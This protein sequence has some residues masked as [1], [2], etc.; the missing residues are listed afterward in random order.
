MLVIK[1]VSNNQKSTD[2]KAKISVYFPKSSFASVEVTAI[3][4]LVCIFLEHLYKL[5]K[6]TQAFFLYR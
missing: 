2:E 1:H 5:I 4:S 6:H 3:S